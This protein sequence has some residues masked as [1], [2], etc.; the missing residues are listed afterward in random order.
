MNFFYLRIWDEDLYINVKKKY[1]LIDFFS[2]S[3]TTVNTAHKFGRKWVGVEMGEHFD[4]VNLPR[5]KKTL[6][7]R[8]MMMSIFKRRFPMSVAG[9]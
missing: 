3:G 6:S 8:F 5:I 1:L 2:G 4:T 7:V 9:R